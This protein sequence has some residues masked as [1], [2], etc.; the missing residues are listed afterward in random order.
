M[1]FQSF[2]HPPA[3]VSEPRD[4]KFYG[5]ICICSSAHR[6][7]N[8]TLA[9]C[10]YSH[11]KADIAHILQVNNRKL[12][13][14]FSFQNFPLILPHSSQNPSP[15]HALT[16]AISLTSLPSLSPGQGS[17]PHVAIWLALQPVCWIQGT[18]CCFIFFSFQNQI[19]ML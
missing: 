18:G 17:W 2:V 9:E 4:P 14:S 15:H 11:A 8:P 3:F 5:S 16:S 6:E 19:I 12:L 7:N 1:S 10:Y 13:I